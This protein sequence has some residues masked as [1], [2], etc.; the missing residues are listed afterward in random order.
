[1]VCVVNR[2]LWRQ[3]QVSLPRVGK[4]IISAFQFHNAILII[5]VPDDGNSSDAFMV[6]ELLD[7]IDRIYLYFGVRCHICCRMFTRR[8]IQ[9]QLQTVNIRRLK[10]NQSLT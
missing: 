6:T 7:C 10:S 5:F 3:D 2:E 9:G 1:M 4:L 8:K